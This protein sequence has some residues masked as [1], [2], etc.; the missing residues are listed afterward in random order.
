MLELGLSLLFAYLAGSINFSLALG[1]FRNLDVRETGSGNAGATNALR[2]AGFR[3]AAGVMVGDIG[4]AIVAV[5]PLATLAHSLGGAD[6]FSLAWL[7]VA[8]GA[9]VTVAHCYPLWH[10]FR[11]GKGFAALLGSYLTLHAPLVGAVLGVWV[12]ALVLSGYVGLAT[13]V[14]AISAPFILAFAMPGNGPELFWLSAAGAAF[15]VWTHRSNIRDLLNGTEH[16]FDRVRV[17]HWFRGG[18]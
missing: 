4:K 2:A 11:G 5:G 7:Q 8:A 14:A 9:S 16:R 18:D 10:E 17:G 6:G 15:T 13:M 12:L 1:R 3:F